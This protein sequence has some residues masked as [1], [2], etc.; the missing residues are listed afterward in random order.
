[1]GIAAA[2]RRYHRAMRKLC[3]WAHRLK[4]ETLALPMNPA[5]VSGLLVQRALD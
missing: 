1:V 4:A 2:F 5:A 3:D